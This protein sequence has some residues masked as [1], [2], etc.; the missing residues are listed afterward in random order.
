VEQI[1]IEQEIPVEKDFLTAVREKNMR[2]Q[3]TP[4][5]V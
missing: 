5:Q 3:N 1:V 2:N 4:A